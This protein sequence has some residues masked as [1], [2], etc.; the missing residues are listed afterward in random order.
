MKYMVDIDNTICYTNDSNYE[1]SEPDL[2]RI[3]HFNKL[4]DEGHDIHYW[5]ARGAVSGKDWQDF[6]MKQLKGWGVKF[7]S[8]RFGKPHY[9]I[10]ID[11]KAINDKE[12]FK[13]Q[14]STD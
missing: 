3:A 7:T 1:K 11:D 10:W 5:T 4:F 9:D 2:D 8:V 13:Q 12:Y 14:G 6:T